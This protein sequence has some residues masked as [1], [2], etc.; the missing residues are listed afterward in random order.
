MNEN[1]CSK[2]GQVD[3]DSLTYRFK[4][5]KEVII[6]LD[7][8]NSKYGI[9]KFRF[10]DYILPRKYFF[11]LLPALKLKKYR[12]ECETKANLTFS[13][14]KSLKDAGFE[15]IQPGIE[16]FS[17]E[18]L[19]KMKKGVSGIRNIL[20]LKLGKLFGIKINYNIL[21]GFPSES[22]S[23]VLRNLY[24]IPFL[25]H[26]D[27]PGTTLQV[28]ITRFS[29]LQMNYK[30]YE[31][32]AV[33][34]H[35]DLYDVI[36]SNAYISKHNISLDKYCYYFK[37]YYRLDSS[38]QTFFNS[39]QT[40]VK[41]WEKVSVSNKAELTFT[42]KKDHLLVVDS[43]YEKKVT[44]RFSQD[45]YKILK[46]CDISIKKRQQIIDD[47]S[48]ELPIKKV[49]ENLDILLEHRLIYEEDGKYLN[50]AIEKY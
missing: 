41:Y 18:S 27:S 40:Q 9:S 50:V 47:L 23:E 15:A 4:D 44:R 21:Y 46:A 48:S 37:T 49:C 17:T 20:T 10:N 33:L 32:K 7:H 36:F 14:F 22:E 5:F 29:P 19:A 42:L 38:F 8:L 24:T 13:N 26:L 43:R 34:E 12:L 28:L 2:V 16:S 39:M 6:Q 3:K 30:D 45:C 35:S 31:S 11:D 1:Q 25:Y